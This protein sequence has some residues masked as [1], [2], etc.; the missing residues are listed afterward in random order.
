VK[1]E[2]LW[3]NKSPEPTAVGA[4][5]SAVA[6]R[7]ASR[8]WLSFFRSA[9]FAR[10]EKRKV[11]KMKTMKL[12][13]TVGLGFV[14][15]L[16]TQSALAQQPLITSFPG[17][18]QLTWTNSPGTNGFTVQWAPTVTG[19][20]SSNWQALDSLITTSTQKTVSVPMFYRVQQGFS[21]A[22]A[23]GVW[24]FTTPSKGNMFYIAQEDGLLS[25]SA[26]FIP[27]SPQ[28]SFTVDITSGKVKNTFLSRS[29]ERVAISGKFVGADRIV[30]DTIPGLM[31]NGIASRLED[32]SRCAGSWTGNL[33]PTDT[34][35]HPISFNVDSRGLETGFTG[36][37][38]NPIGRLFA[39]TNGIVIGFFYTG[40]E[41]NGNPLEN[42]NQ[43]KISGVL[44]GNTIQGIYHLDEGNSLPRGT[45]TLTR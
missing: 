38:G 4:V 19:P 3:P 18:G 29:S 28:G 21:L 8:R 33:Y 23:R 20:W 41:G 10:Q 24:I 22:S 14:L 11:Q 37:S 44:S 45:F 1:I 35:T 9:A 36:F 40:E 13:I 2:T 16:A 25:E 39:L 34:A 15:A 7:A 12:A 27:Q 26:M 32:A 30:L 31:T 42:Y 43:I 6:V 5:S 17:N